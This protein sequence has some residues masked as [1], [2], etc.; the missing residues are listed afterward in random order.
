[1]NSA[2]WSA[3]NGEHE[4]SIMLRRSTLR[5]QQAEAEEQRRMEAPCA[6][7]WIC[8]A[9][10]WSRALFCFNNPSLPPEAVSARKVGLIVALLSGACAACLAIPHLETLLLPD[11]PKLSHTRLEAM[12]PV[13]RAFGLERGLRLAFEC[14]SILTGVSL[15]LVLCCTKR[16]HSHAGE[17]AWPHSACVACVAIAL[18]VHGLIAMR[19]M[20]IVDEVHINAFYVS[21]ACAEVFGCPQL[22]GCPNGGTVAFEDLQRQ[23]MVYEE[24]LNRGSAYTGEYVVPPAP[25]Y[26]AERAGFNCAAQRWQPTPTPLM[27][28]LSTKAF[29]GLTLGLEALQIY[30]CARARVA[31]LSPPAGSSMI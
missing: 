16:V 26:P 4:K 1:M 8:C 20:A 29:V 13:T 24:E 19:W 11:T 5:A 25:Y 14:A 21:R 15:L 7:V 9:D 3:S 2:R 27:M 22:G 12:L 17:G 10:G 6:S 31:L 30:V 28:Q 18:A 23:A